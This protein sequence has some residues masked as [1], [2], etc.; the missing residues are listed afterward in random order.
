MSDGQVLAANQVS[1]LKLK[2]ILTLALVFLHLLPSLLL[3]LRRRLPLLRWLRPTPRPFG[4]AGT[5]VRPQ[6]RLSKRVTCPEVEG[7]VSG[8]GGWWRRGPE[9]RRWSVCGRDK[10]GGA[11]RGGRQSG[12]GGSW[13]R[14]RKRSGGDGES[15]GGGGDGDGGGGVGAAGQ[16]MRVG[17]GL[18]W[19]G[20]GG[21]RPADAPSLEEVAGR[22]RWRRSGGGRGAGG[23]SGGGG[24]GTARTAG[25]ASRRLSVVPTGRES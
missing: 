21:A 6:L 24:G 5:A 4:P 11:P 16:R 7:V 17:P 8:V 14:R 19:L 22:R 10:H 20:A 25:G 1:R 13:R 23:R 12:E 3:L 9:G 2:L 18:G 15:G